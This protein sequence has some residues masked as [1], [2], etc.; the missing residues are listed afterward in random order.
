MNRSQKNQSS[1]KTW[2]TMRLYL[3]VQDEI[4]LL[5]E[6]T[7]MICETSRSATNNFGLFAIG[8]AIAFMISAIPAAAQSEAAA[9]G[10][11]GTWHVTVSL[12]NCSTGQNLGP[13]F[14]SLLLFARGGTLTGTTRN[15]FFQPGQRSDD[16]GIWWQTGTNAYSADS[17][18]F[19]LFTNST[20]PIFQSGTQ[21]I[22]QAITVNGDT[23]ESVAITRF[24]DTNGSLLSTGCA[25]ATATRYH[26]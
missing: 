14:S 1:I 12:V 6:D 9:T 10:L 17:E 24:Y 20:P 18:A 5:S 16:F 15:P 25:H 22:T 8:L 19:I 21:R 23:F 2:P 26:K 4:V 7:N 11:Q 3:R 13:S